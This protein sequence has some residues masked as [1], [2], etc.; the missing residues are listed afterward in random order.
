MY[1]MKFNIRLAKEIGI[2]PAGYVHN[3]FRE[4][5]LYFCA[6]TAGTIVRRADWIYALNEAQLRLMER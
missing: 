3:L 4:I 1:V 2:P 5:S 6:H